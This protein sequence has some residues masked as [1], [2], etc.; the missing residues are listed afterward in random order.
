[1]TG[2]RLETAIATLILVAALMFAVAGMPLSVEAAVYGLA[3]MLVA[4][5]L[6][7]AKWAWLGARAGGRKSWPMAIAAALLLGS[8]SAMAGSMLAEPAD[9]NNGHPL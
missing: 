7:C 4:G 2:W 6:I 8:G 3:A 9:L 1:M 5:G